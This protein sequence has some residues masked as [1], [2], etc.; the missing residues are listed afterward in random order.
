MP[1]EWPEW[2]DE[3]FCRCIIFLINCLLILRILGAVSM[4]FKE[5]VYI[6]CSNNCGLINRTIY[7]SPCSDV[8]PN[9][10]N[11]MDR[12]DLLQW[13][14]NEQDCVSNHQPHDCLLNCLSRHRSMK[15]LTLRVT[16]LC[17]GNSPVTGEFPAQRASNAENASMWWRHYVNL[18]RLD[19][20]FHLVIF[21]K[22][23]DVSTNKSHL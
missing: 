8:L 17:V 18:R 13:R 20:H 7:S 10:L 23:W 14:H 12:F 3:Y 1:S 4:P 2:L 5:F 11:A 6:S 21:T 16:G 19:R 15:T 22:V 9:I